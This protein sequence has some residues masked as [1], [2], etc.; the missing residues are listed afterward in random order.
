MLE[1]DDSVVP[2]EMISCLERLLGQSDR[3]KALLSGARVWVTQY[4]AVMLDGEVCLPWH[5]DLSQQHKKPFRRK[6]G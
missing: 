6:A 5:W 3:L 1:K 4:Y 2:L